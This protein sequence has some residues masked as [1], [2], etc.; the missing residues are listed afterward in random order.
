MYENIYTYNSVC[1][2]IY[3]YLYAFIYIICKL[4]TFQAAKL[5]NAMRFK[6][7]MKNNR[8]DENESEIIAIS[9]KIPIIS[10]K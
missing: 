5:C 3:S 8:K 7:K 10:F 9:G 6:W 2:Y 1:K 4:P